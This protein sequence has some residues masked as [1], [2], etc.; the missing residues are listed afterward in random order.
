MVG[1]SGSWKQREPLMLTHGKRRIWC[2]P[3]NNWWVGWGLGS[4][5]ARW[6]WFEVSLSKGV[7]NLHTFATEK[8]TRE[9]E[10]CSTWNTILSHIFSKS[11][12]LSLI[13]VWL[14]H[15]YTQLVEIHFQHSGGQSDNVSLWVSLQPASTFLGP[16]PTESTRMW[17]KSERAGILL[18]GSSTWLWLQNTGRMWVSV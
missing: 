14:R 7:N 17:T 9:R 15:S 6:K 8:T 2:F 13:L 10:E 11:S 16:Y 4:P 18:S 12:E 5:W 3:T 1:L